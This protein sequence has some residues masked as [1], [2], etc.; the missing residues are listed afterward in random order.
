MKLLEQ[1]REIQ[2]KQKSF[3]YVLNIVGWDSATEAPKAAFP[4]RAKMMAFISGELFKLGTSKEYQEVVYGLYDQLDDL[5]DSVQREVKKAKKDL[6]KL[7]KIPQDEFVEYQ[8]LVNM[9]QK[10][11]EDAKKSFK[12]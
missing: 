3:G 2:Q 5:E 12:Q 1:F 8:T 7:I 4:R 11:W 10:V 9:S 6:D